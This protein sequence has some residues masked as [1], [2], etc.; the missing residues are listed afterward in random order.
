M[1]NDKNP[2]PPPILSGQ[3]EPVASQIICLDAVSYA[4]SDKVGIGNWDRPAIFLS[5][6]AFWWLITCFGVGRSRLL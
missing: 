6:V 2:G 5:R 1:V 3:K 4:L